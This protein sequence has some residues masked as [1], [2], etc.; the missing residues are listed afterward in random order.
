MT[1]RTQRTF[2]GEADPETVASFQATVDHAVRL[3]TKAEML[4]AQ[5]REALVVAAALAQRIPNADL[6]DARAKLQAAEVV[7]RSL[8]P[9]PSNVVLP[10]THCTRVRGEMTHWPVAPAWVYLLKRDN[11]V[12]YVGAT[13]RPNVRMAGHKE[14]PW[15]HLEM[16][17]CPDRQSAWA[18]EGDLIF[19]HQPPL[20][21]ADTRKRRYVH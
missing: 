5:T 12:I 15:T 11:A 14:K 21:K 16:I 7:G 19:Q 9:A 8:I 2:F 13:E 20:N 17:A 3:H 10:G 4:R 6:I 18:L 1:K